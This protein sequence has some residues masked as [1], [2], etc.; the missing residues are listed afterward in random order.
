MVASCQDL[1]PAE[2]DAGGTLEFSLNIAHTGSMHINNRR[3]S[4]EN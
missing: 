2:P 3:G 4:S 1:E